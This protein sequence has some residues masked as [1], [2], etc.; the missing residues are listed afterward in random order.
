MSWIYNNGSPGA[1]NRWTIFVIPSENPYYTDN[2]TWY[3][4]IDLIGLGMV[5]VN[6][7]T[8]TPPYS[9]FTRSGAMTDKNVK[10]ENINFHSLD[11]NVDLQKMILTN[12]NI[13]VELD[14]YAPEL[15]IHD[16]QCKNTG[17]YQIGGA[18]IIVT[19]ANRIIGCYGNYNI[20]WT[21]SDDVMNY[22]YNTS[23]SYQY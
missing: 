19:G 2:F 16:S 14:N 22:N 20:L 1:T 6:N 7:T 5:D 17:F 10:A 4:Y 9:I 13:R 11:A 23:G 15:N 3:D 12:C 21:S 18:T 8:H